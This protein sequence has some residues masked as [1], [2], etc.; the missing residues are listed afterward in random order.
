MGDMDIHAKR[1][2]KVR[3]VECSD[4]QVNY[5]GH[6]DPRKV[7]KIGEVYEVDHTE[8]GNWKTDVFLVGFDGGFNSVCFEDVAP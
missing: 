4:E 5:G 3:F 6:A 1:G 2:H 8:V 7:L